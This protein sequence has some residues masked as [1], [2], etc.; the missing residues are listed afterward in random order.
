VKLL[1]KGGLVLNVFTD[2]LERK[3]V[4]IEDGIIT[5]VGDYT[6]DDADITEDVCGKV[7]CPGFIDA[8]VHI[9]S[10]MLTPANFAAV[11]LPHGTTSVIA[12][13][14]E[15]ANVAGVS[16]IEYMLEAS[17]NLPVSIYF[18]L[19][20]CVPAT[21]LDEAGAVLIA[22]DLR[23]L[24][25]HK[26]VL[27]LGEMM[28]Y[29]GVLAGDTDVM[30]K[31]LD[32]RKLGKIVN[33][34]APL[35][36]GKELDKY[37]ASGIRDDHECSSFEEALERIRKG[38]IVMIRQ[39][40]AAKN[41][42]ALLPLFD[43][44]YNRRCVLVTDDRHPMHLI[45]DGHI[46]NII[47]LAANA[48]KSPVTAVRMATIQAAMHF[49]LTDIGA[50]APGYKA[51]ILVLDDLYKV[52]VRDVYKNGIKVVSCGV[53]FKIDTPDVRV[54]IE[55]RVRGSFKLKELSKNDFYIEPLS[56]KCRVIGM[57]PHQLI[58]DEL[59]M[60]LD[61]DKENGIDVNRDILKAAVIERHNGTGHIG[62]GYVKG[63]GLKS[64]AVASSVSHDSHNIVV[65]GTNEHDMVAAA[66]RVRS[67]NGGLAAVKDGGVIADMPLPVAGL[68]SDMSAVDAANYSEKLDLA[69]CSLGCKDA[70]SLFMSMSFI[71]LPV[72]PRLKLTTHGLADVESQKIVSLF[73]NA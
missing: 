31:I 58:T 42:E 44:P 60:K 12:D 2:E 39:G 14:H 59:V 29:P 51:D 36:S 37:I 6:D 40:S 56:S 20:S 11:C 63:I 34:H 72:I 47:K 32:A 25:A 9:E 27:G 52:K 70:E 23:P 17:E 3:N 19:P 22:D 15:I 65:I 33:G 1:L 49:G 54:D 53:P 24:Y 35:L 5:G 18:M 7:I 62:I 30:K 61:F 13:P 46:D 48:G 4:L 67:M 71:A 64:G 68:M 21:L 57:N 45:R 16:G 28:N 10:S 38:Q 8:H 50:V 73:I 66:N 41:L 55:E 43:E 69:V 26:R